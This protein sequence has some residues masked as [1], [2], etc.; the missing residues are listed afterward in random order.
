[1]ET[2]PPI[3]SALWTFKEDE[4]LRRYLLAN[5]PQHF[6][7]RYPPSGS[8]V[9]IV[10]IG[11]GLKFIFRS[12]H[13]Y[14]RQGRGKATQFNIRCDPALA[15]IVGADILVLDD[16]ESALD[17]LI[18]ENIKQIPSVATLERQKLDLRY[19]LDF[20]PISQT[21]R[22]PPNL[23]FFRKHFQAATENESPSLA[24]AIL[25]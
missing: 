14:I 13:M 1:M 3:Y 10:R 15:A 18:F 25:Q 22:P 17:Q 5:L 23:E 19:S 16:D 4:A 24:H 11:K 6:H 21:T 20:P 2:I 8:P 12:Y 7:K 9:E